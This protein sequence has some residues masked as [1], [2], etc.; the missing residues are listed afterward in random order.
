MI[1]A[2]PVLGTDGDDV[3]AHD[4]H[5]RGREPVAE[6]LGALGHEQAADVE[7]S[8]IA[9]TDHADESAAVDH[10]RSV[11]PSVARGLKERFRALAASAARGTAL[12]AAACVWSRS[13]PRAPAA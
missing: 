1:S 6:R 12:I 3:R 5:D 11:S 10:P 13:A 9:V 7:A 4:L 8:E 2:S